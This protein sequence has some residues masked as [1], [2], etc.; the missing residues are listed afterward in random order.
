MTQKFHLTISNI[1]KII[2]N[3]PKSQLCSITRLVPEIP[4]ILIIFIAT[5]KAIQ[6]ANLRET[7]IEIGECSQNCLPLD[8]AGA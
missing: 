5:N 6:S 3:S 1:L 2:I 8:C 7:F 4:I